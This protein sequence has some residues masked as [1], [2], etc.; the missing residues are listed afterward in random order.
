LKALGLLKKKQKKIK[1]K[2]E[3]LYSGIY[4]DQWGKIQITQT[5]GI[6]F[7]KFFFIGVNIHL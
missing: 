5:F 3:K 4:A 7:N 1:Y 6:V 2:V